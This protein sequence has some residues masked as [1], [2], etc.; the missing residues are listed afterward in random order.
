M[1]ERV[2]LNDVPEIAVYLDH[3]GTKSFSVAYEL[4]VNGELRTIGKSV[5]VCYN[6]IENNTFEV[7]EE[8]RFALEKI[9]K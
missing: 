7:S 3:I 2:L 5:L 8:L 4:R 1:R 9:R 6:S